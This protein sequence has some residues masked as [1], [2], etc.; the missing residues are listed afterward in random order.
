EWKKNMVK[1]E[2]KETKIVETRKFT[3]KDWIIWLG[4]TVAGTISL[5]FIFDSFSGT[6]P[7]IDALTLVMALVGQFLM[8]YRYREQWV[9][10]GVLNVVSIYQ[11]A[12][13]GNM[14]LV[15]LY[16]AFLINN[17]YGVYM[18]SKETKQTKLELN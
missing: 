3:A 10:W 18:W 13:L 1:D 15:A 14:S 7:Y 12:T 17:I 6:Q 16:I 2:E 11:W 4:V 8:L 5:G 9:F